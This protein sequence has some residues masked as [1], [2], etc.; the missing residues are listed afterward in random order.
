ME[1]TKKPVV[2]IKV[3]NPITYLEHNHTLKMTL[4]DFLKLPPRETAKERREFAQEIFLMV[5]DN[6]WKPSGTGRM[7]GETL[8]LKRRNRTVVIEFVDTP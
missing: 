3:M 6:D 8:T 7:L 2:T 1:K 4:T 5:E